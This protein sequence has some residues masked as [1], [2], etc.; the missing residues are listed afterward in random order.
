MA[1]D[2][3]LEALKRQEPL[4]RSEGVQHVALFGSQARGDARP[5]SD[6]DLL[7]SFQP[8]RRVSLID[9]CRL[10]RLLT[11]RLNLTVQVT[12]APIRRERLRKSI[13]AESVDVL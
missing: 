3:I 9:L 2:E 1:R 7:V 13:Q 8:G 11:D 6:V 10:E 12:P 5:D 4:F